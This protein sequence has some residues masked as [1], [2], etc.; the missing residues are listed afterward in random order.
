MKFANIL[1]K[2]KCAVMAQKDLILS[3]LFIRFAP[4][5]DSL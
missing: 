5:L 4:K 2:K 3:E 1:P